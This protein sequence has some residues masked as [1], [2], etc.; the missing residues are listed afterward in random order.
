MTGAASVG[1][2]TV[3]SGGAL[4]PG[5]PGG[6]GTS[7]TIAGNLAFQSGAIYLVNLNS[8]TA[9]RAN[10]GGTVTLNGAVGVFLLPGSYSTQTT[11]DI[12]DPTSIS[13]KFTGFTSINEPGFGGTLTYIPTEVL[14]NLTANLGAGGGGLN[15]NQQNVAKAIDNYFNNGGT[16][17]ANFFPVFG[18][19]GAGWAMCSASSPARRR[20]ALSRFRPR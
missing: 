18:L 15:T 17:P 14:L 9:S 10:V 13:G 16:L 12:V 3:N 11:Y 8:T 6:P 19:T 7:M 5:S 1:D 4:M 2:V 20:P